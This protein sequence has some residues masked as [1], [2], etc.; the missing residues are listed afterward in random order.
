MNEYHHECIRYLDENIRTHIRNPR[1][2]LKD[3]EDFIESNKMH[4]EINE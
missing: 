1:T 4:G 2:N 3:D